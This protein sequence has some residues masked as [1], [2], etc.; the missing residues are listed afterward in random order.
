MARSIFLTGFMG[1]GKTSV[2][3]PLAHAL[4]LSFVDL[5]KEIVRRVGKPIPAIFAEDGEPAFRALEAQTLQALSYPAVVALGGGAL[6]TVDVRRFVRDNGVTIFL[7]WPIEVL[8]ARILGDPNRP[9]A[10]DQAALHRL[11]EARLPTYLE[12]DVVWRSR[13]GK[14]SVDTVVSNLL[15]RLTA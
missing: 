15:K 11:Y 4:G 7:H 9:L 5:D 14:E 1:A 6:G 12:A 3:R 10:R 2:G 13:T 8:S